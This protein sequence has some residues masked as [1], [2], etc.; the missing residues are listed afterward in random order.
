V[1]HYVARLGTAALVLGA[2]AR[3]AGAQLLGNPVYFSP[4]QPT[5]LTLALD[6]GSTL[7]RDTSGTRFAVGG[8]SVKP[9]NLGVR[10]TL[11][12]PLITVGVGV[13]IY[14]PDLTGVSADKETQFMG[15][16][17]LKLF[18]P[19]LVPVGISLQAGA[20]YLKQTFGTISRKTI[21][22]PIGLGVAIKP[23]TPGLSVEVWGAPRLQFNAVSETG[24]GSRVQAGIG[25]S[26]GVNL[27]M[28]MGLGLH[29]AADYSKL[30]AKASAGTGSLTLPETQTMVFGAGLHY[31]F[32][33]PGLPI[34]PII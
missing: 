9:N 1:K 31:T 32:T 18:S 19:P 16:A 5:G 28:P 12:L 23:P 30:G 17:A 33:I 25:A 2:L 29:L 4:K 15:N 8:Q 21:T 13:G 24:A 10:A 26:G 14:N 34:V 11:G 22:V 7:R 20:G 27:G 6:F 3:P